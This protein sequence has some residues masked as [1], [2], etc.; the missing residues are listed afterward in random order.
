VTLTLLVGSG[1]RSSTLEAHGRYGR[2]QRVHG[3]ENSAV[4]D[5]GVGG[6]CG[7]DYSSGAVGRGGAD[8]GSVWIK[9]MVLLIFAYGGFESALAP[10]RKPRIRGGTR[11]LRCLWH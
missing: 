6:S 8:A 10:M 5:G 4:A 9:A 11:L 3:G 7:Y 2:E 1:W